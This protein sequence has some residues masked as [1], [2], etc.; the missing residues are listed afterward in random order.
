MGLRDKFINHYST[1]RLAQKYL[2]YNTIESFV[3][4]VNDNVRIQYVFLNFNSLLILS[5]GAL[6][7]FQ[8]LLT[9]EQFALRHL[10]CFKNI[11]IQNTKLSLGHKIIIL[12]K[13]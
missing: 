6:L 1:M 12:N 5:A 2:L 11:S 13:C 7:K 8:F 10:T 3:S 4:F 9:F